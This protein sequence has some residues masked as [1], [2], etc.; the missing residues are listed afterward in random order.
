MSLRKRDVIQK[1]H[2]Y[3]V[4]FKINILHIPNK[5]TFFFIL[6]SKSLFFSQALNFI[7]YDIHKIRLISMVLC[8]F[9]AY[10][11]V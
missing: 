11:N 8:I 1:T 6:L 10:I 5:G 2:Y 3:A 7:L 9:V 4:H